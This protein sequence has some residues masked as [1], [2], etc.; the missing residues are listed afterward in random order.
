MK[1]EFSSLRRS[2]IKKIALISGAGLLGAW[3]TKARDLF[4]TP[5]WYAQGK[6]VP[7]ML[8]PFHS[9]LSV[10]YEGLNRL[11]DFYSEAG[12]DGFFANCASSEMYKLN[13]EER[14]RITAQVVKR[15]NGSVPVVST[16]SF[17]KSL[18]EKATFTK[19]M[20]DVGVDAVILVTAHI[21]NKEEDDH[22]F[23][24]HL[25]YFMNLTDSIPLGTYECPSPYKR[26]LSPEVY[27]FLV[28]TGRFIYHK[29]T[30]ENIAAIKIK[31][32]RS[33]NT[34]LQLY[35]AHT[36]TAVSSLRAGAAGMS[37]ISGN[38]YPE[39]I[40][41][42]CKNANNPEKKEETDWIQSEITQTEKILSSGY[43]KSA[44]YFLRKRGLDIQ[45]ISR[46]RSKPLSVEQMAAL[47]QL[48][49]RFLGWCNR[50][51]IVPVEKRR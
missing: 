30:T 21:A 35:N 3:D 29:D 33:E 51:G 41:W 8:T 4:E 17:G 18:E 14:L 47:D 23:I 13:D 32:K 39:I 43:P 45:D 28:R 48:Y 26:I 42:I 24:N 46:S 15:I 50:L 10:D 44:K 22:I 1:Q 11:I 25:E 7:V 37:P 49:I 5:A 34:A 9:D 19:R 20:H 40:S 31:L 12:A 16:G 6:Y 2:F 27:S 38:L 36:A